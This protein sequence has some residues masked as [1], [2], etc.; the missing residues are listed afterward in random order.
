MSGMEAHLQLRQQFEEVINNYQ[1]SDQALKL[2]QK[3]PLVILLGVTGSGKNTIINHL[4]G[5]GRYHFIVSDTTRQPKLRDGNM[6]INGVQYFFR[7][8]ADILADLKKGA[9]LEAEIVHKNHVYGTSIREL[10]RAVDSGKIPVN[11]VDVGGTISIRKAKPD[12]TF[13]FLLPPSFKEWRYRLQGREVMSEEELTNRLK[14]AVKVLE[15]GL[16][17]D[18]IFVVN[19]SSRATA[20]QI[21]DYIQGNKTAFANENG[22]VI[23]DQIQQELKDFIG[24]R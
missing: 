13:I 9:F 6:E 15:E 23:A 21:D 22:R 5:F 19:E 2:L 10:K 16:R 4:V 14:T 3:T 12:T 18:Y 24:T 7:S 17:N 1:P 11:E 20:E 8:E